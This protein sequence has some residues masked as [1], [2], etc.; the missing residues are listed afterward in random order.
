MAGQEWSDHRGVENQAMKKTLMLSSRINNNLCRLCGKPCN[1]QGLEKDAENVFGH[2]I[3]FKCHYDAHWHINHAMSVLRKE[4]N[5]D[6]YYE[7]PNLALEALK[8]VLSTQRVFDRLPPGG[9]VWEPTDGNRRVGDFLRSLGYEVISS[10]INPRFEGV[11]KCN[12]L[13]AKIKAHVNVS[14]IVFNPPFVEFQRVR[15]TENGITAN[16]PKECKGWL[17]HALNHAEIVITLLPATL[18]NKCFFK[19]FEEKLLCTYKIPSKL[20]FHSPYEDRPLKMLCNWFVW[21]RNYIRP[22]GERWELHNANKEFYIKQ[23]KIY[24]PA[25]ITS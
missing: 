8:E 20:V 7:T 19:K 22:E 1:L 25:K 4:K 10:D 14:A 13:E 16:W 17:P 24:E 9:I 3:H 11:H 12:F 23:R 21:C 6:E 5:P 2:P 18:E 15:R